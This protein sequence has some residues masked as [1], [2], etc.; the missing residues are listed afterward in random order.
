MF[1][2]CGHTSISYNWT[3]PLDLNT[4]EPEW[5]VFVQNGTY[6]V[7]KIAESDS[8][9][10][11]PNNMSSTSTLDSSTSSMGIETE[12]P[13]AATPAFSQPS[14]DTPNSGLSTGAKAG[15]G[16]GAS[17]FVICLAAGLFLVWR[18]RPRPV[19]STEIPVAKEYQ[20]PELEDNPSQGGPGVFGAGAQ[21]AGRHEIDGRGVK[22][23]EQQPVEL[24]T[25]QA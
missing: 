5:K 22:V 16:V 19:Q 4:T 24:A 15:I 10:I 21:D 11:K 6:P 25:E 2:V 18:R 17:L 20:K 13:A 8:F 1:D 7:T 3:I 14:S 23:L 12:A 9:R